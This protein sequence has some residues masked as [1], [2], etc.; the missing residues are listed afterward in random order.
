[1]EENTLQQV[2]PEIQPEVTQINP[3][4]QPQEV[5]RENSPTPQESFQELRKRAEQA[6]RER[7]EAVGFIRQLE[8]YAIQQQQPQ[9][10]A[11]EDYN[12]SYAD[13]D[14]I[15]GKHLKAEFSALRKEL[16]AQRKQAE[17]SRRMAETNM[18]ESKLRSKFNDFDSIVTHENIQRL[19]ELKPEIAASLH[20]TQD[21][22]SKAA[23]TYTILKDLGIA[24]AH[25]NDVDKNRAQQNL[26]KP[27]A[28]T[29][30][31][32]QSPL[33]HATAFSSGELT[34]DRKRQIW[35]QMQDNARRR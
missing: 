2:N 28:A 5:A 27:H 19:R 30:I 12:P 6:E 35:Q 7:N 18:V 13:D 10:P 26:N 8:Q 33:S 29:S 24:R 21:L 31:A 11:K 16:E 25:V 15:E 20:Q 23:A 9:Q 22:Y 17:E 1:M 32:S 3:E 14:L 34:D 4:N